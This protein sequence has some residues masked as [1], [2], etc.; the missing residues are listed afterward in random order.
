M[1]LNQSQQGQA[2]YYVGPGSVTVNNIGKLATRQPSASDDAAKFFQ[3]YGV[4][5]G[6]LYMDIASAAVTAATDGTME[7]FVA[8]CKEV[9]LQPSGTPG[10]ITVQG[11][12]D[13]ATWV[14]ANVVASADGF[15]RIQSAY[16][17]LRVSVGSGTFS[18]YMMIS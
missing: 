18:L 3:R 15:V 5:S 9:T 11:S 7:I 8:G 2:L 14:T 1:A 12:L 4:F 13:R 17:W 16:K 10:T 6:F